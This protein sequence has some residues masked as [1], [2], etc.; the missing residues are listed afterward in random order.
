D[1]LM[2]KVEAAVKQTGILR[3]AIAGGVSANR[4][5]RARLQEKEAA[6]G[7]EVFIPPLAY[8][9][10]NAA[11]I[12]MAGSL[13]FEAGARGSLSDEPVPRWAF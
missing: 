8:C 4:G 5:L 9:T 3:V 11:M 7:W 6:A 12:A 10:D 13:M 1:I 2:E